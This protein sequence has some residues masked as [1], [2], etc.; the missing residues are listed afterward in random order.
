MKALALLALVAAAR[1]SAAAP[2]AGAEIEVWVR[3]DAH[4]ERGAPARLRTRRFNLDRLPLVESERPDAQYGETFRYRG[5][6]VRDLLDRYAPDKPLDLA[7]LHFANGMAIPIPFRDAAAMKR[8][9]PFVARALR[10]PRRARLQVNGFPPVSHKD[11]SGERRPIEFSGNKLVVAERWHPEVP[12]GRESEFSPW[13]Y[14]DT[15]TGIELVTARAY[16]ARFE[17]GTEVTVRRGLALFRENCQFCHGVRH[18]GAS[19]GWDFVDAPAIRGYRESAAH[20]YHNVAVKPRNAG[21]LGLMMPA[22]AFL[23]EPDAAAL[24]DWLTAISDRPTDAGSK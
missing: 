4:P 11:A 24:R 10:S 2:P 20:L 14:V 19:F 12:S 18:V 3:G 7:I 6:A 22:L 5:V 9:D 1:A 16:Y 8:L 17:A 13:V 15:L 21:Q 23:S